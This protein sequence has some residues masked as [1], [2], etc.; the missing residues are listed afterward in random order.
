MLGRKDSSFWAKWRKLNHEFEIISGP[1]SNK[2]VVNIFLNSFGNKFLDS[3][4]NKEKY[5]EFLMKYETHANKFRNENNDMIDFIID[6][7]E[8]A[9]KELHLRKASDYNELPVEH[10]LCAHQG[11]DI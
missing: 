3:K 5:N 7:I 11:A 8:E 9:V 10:V 6:D 4:T 2:K 1:N